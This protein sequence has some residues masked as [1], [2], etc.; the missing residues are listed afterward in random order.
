MQPYSGDLRLR[1]V[2]AYARQEGSMRQLAARFHVSVGCVRDLIARY[3]AT[4]NVTPKPHGGGYPAKLD[5]THRAVVRTL[6]QAEPDATLAELCTRLQ[7]STQVTVSGA[8]MSRVL[9]QLGL[10]RK[11]KLSRR[12]ASPP[13]RPTPARHL[14][15]DDAADRSCG[16]H[17]CR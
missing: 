10:P 12:R 15:R 7:A 17:L 3:R 13:R 5:A 2:H 6:V 14:S 4:G 1:I 16:P 11:K 8:T 9:R